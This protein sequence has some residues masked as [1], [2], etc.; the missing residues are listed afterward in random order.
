MIQATNGGRYLIRQMVETIG[1]CCGRRNGWQ[2]VAVA[3]EAA[4]DVVGN[5][6]DVRRWRFVKEVSWRRGEMKVT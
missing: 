4:S 3:I 5:V 1:V 6:Q 2:W